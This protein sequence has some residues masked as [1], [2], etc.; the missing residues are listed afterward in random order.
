ML[1]GVCGVAF[2]WIWVLWLPR[3]DQSDVVQDRLHLVFPSGQLELA[4]HAE[5]GVS[6]VRRVRS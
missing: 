3:H 6:G 2:L 1:R 4:A 5:A